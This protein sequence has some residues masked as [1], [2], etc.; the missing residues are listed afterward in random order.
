LIELAKTKD[1]PEL[2][3]IITNMWNKWFDQHKIEM[4]E[5]YLLRRIKDNE[6]LIMRDEKSI[7]GHLIYSTN[8]NKAHIEDIYINEYLRHDGRATQLMLFFENRV[9]MQGYEIITSDCDITNIASINMHLKLEYK[10]NGYLNDFWG[11][12]EPSISF[13]KLIEQNEMST[14]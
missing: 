9:I 3:K 1:L 6:V 10:I 7:I 11:E 12:N 8:W 13:I 2:M 14:L 4:C 5:N